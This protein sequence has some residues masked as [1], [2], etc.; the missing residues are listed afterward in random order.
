MGTMGES[1]GNRKKFSSDELS[2]EDVERWKLL[3]A[4][5]QGRLNP[6]CADIH[7]STTNKEM[8]TLDP[9]NQEACRI[10]LDD[11]RKK[12]DAIDLKLSALLCER[13]HCAENISALKAEIGEQVLQP[14]NAKK[15]VLGNVLGRASSELQTPDP[16]KHIPLHH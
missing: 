13:L 9:A 16:G 14:R 1:A 4:Q 11:W 5:K 2:G 3:F 8:T 12:I 15:E 7:P 6:P 10:R